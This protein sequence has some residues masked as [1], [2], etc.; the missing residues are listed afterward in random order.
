M[1]TIAELT[2]SADSAMDYQ[3]VYAIIDQTNGCIKAAAEVPL[4]L[5]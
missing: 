1:A 3:S 5:A 4:A 2:Y